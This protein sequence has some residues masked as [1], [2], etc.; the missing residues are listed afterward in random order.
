M[1]KTS[2][3]RIAVVGGML[4]A[5][6]A[7][8]AAEDLT[9]ETPQDEYGKPAPGA[10]GRLGTI[11]F[12]NWGYFQENV[13]DTSQWQYRPRIFLPWVFGNGWIATLRTD[14]PMLYTNNT[15]PAKPE[16]GY[17]G[18][19]GNIFFEPILLPNLT[20]RTSLRF[21]LKSPKGPPFGPDNQYQIAP[22]AGFTYR[23]PDVLR[24]ITFSPFVR[25][26]RGFDGDD[27]ANLIS[28][29]QFIPATTF[30]IDDR[31]SL[32][33]YPENPIT[34]NSNTSKWFVPL[35]LLLIHRWKQ[36]IEFAFGG[37]TKIGN[38][39]GATYDYIVNGRVTLFF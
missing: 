20:F 26:L 1:K 2:W 11:R 37:A 28:T 39:S 38:P 10:R 8:F 36:N 24:G 21:V 16:G 6:G 19:I 12:D 9:Y 18:G 27:G 25:W 30:R 22:G 35:D 32:A 31:W 5:A 14:I 3:H 17:S 23:M 34:Y 4:S 15:G 29:V 13:N 33:F 7:A